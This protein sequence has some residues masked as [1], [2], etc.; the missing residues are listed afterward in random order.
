MAT[1]ISAFWSLRRVL[2]LMVLF[3]LPVAVHAAAPAPPPVE[4]PPAPPAEQPVPKAPAVVREFDSGKYHVRVDRAAQKLHIDAPKPMAWLEPT[5]TANQPVEIVRDGVSL[6]RGRE[7]IAAIAKGRKLFISKVEG[8]WAAA[9]IVHR[10]KQE[11]GWV[12]IADLKPLPGEPRAYKHLQNAGGQFLSA[13]ML[14]QKAKQFDD[15]LYAAAELAAL[16][17]RGEMPAKSQLLREWPAK[18]DPAAGGKGLSVLLVAGE[19]GGSGAEIP[20][21]QKK[22]VADLIR[23]FNA[24]PKR[25][26]PLGFYTWSK[27]L[28]AIFRQDRMLQTPLEKLAD[29]QSIAEALRADPALRTA[30]Q[31][32]LQLAYRL[33]NPP[34]T[35][36]SSDLSPLIGDEVTVKPTEVAQ[37]RILPPSISHESQLFLRLFPSP[38]P[39]PDDFDLMKTLVAEIRAG[40]IDLTPTPE[41]GWY[42]HQ[43]W[44]L[45]PLLLP[46]KMPEASH[47][48]VGEEYRKHLEELFKGTLALTRE[49][50]VKQLDFPPPAAAAEPPP[51]VEKKPELFIAPDLVIEPLPQM[52]LRRAQSYLFVREVLAAAFG[53]EALAEIHRQTPD[54]PVKATLGEELQQMATI[55]YGAHVAASRQLGKDEEPV[56]AGI[57][58][59]GENAAIEL[60]AWHQKSASD[61]DLG[62]DAR[63]MVP[64]FL[65]PENQRI[66][67]WCM[68]G[69]QTQEAYVSFAKHPTITA[70][71]EA[72]DAV[73][74][75]KTFDVHYWGQ[76]LSLASPIFAEVWVTKLLN[77]DEFRRHCDAYVTP[78]AIVANLE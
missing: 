9:T 32:H 41:S 33:T 21:A 39:V 15:G 2:G 10:G 56:P 26:K 62:W 70:T 47:L 25:S 55:F 60:L 58:A 24:D 45:Q 63:M 71:S 17:G 3:S 16:D 57:G 18:V 34:V 53:E 4:S 67:V 29:A 59:N 61:P 5:V 74:V 72:G 20:A 49:T 30:Y 77:R 11:S 14:I 50:H 35:G 69:W 68:L 75:A 23:A 78:G 19:L 8:K 73:D 46:E 64:V 7:R 13:A 22:A 52:Y 76:G 42:D 66:K 31:K 1:S 65:D 54:G 12:Q 43:T 36:G 6:Q 48:G 40:K 38:Q 27:A 28:E 44:A 37:W 51:I